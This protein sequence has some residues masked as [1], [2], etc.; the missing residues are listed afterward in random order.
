MPGQKYAI[1]NS[2]HN[3]EITTKYSPEDR[4]DID[5]Q[6]GMGKLNSESPQYRARQYLKRKLCGV[7]GCSCSDAWG[8]RW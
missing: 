8:E 1:R 2:F 7:T 3:T 6:I 5:E 4:D